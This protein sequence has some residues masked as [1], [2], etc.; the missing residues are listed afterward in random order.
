V[1]SIGGAAERGSENNTKKPETQER[2]C[3]VKCPLLA[4]PPELEAA[5]R[6]E[7][8]SIRAGQAPTSTSSSSRETPPTVVL[9]PGGESIDSEVI[10]IR[11]VTP[12]SPL[13]V[14]GPNADAGIAV[15]A[16]RAGA[17]G[18]VY[19]GMGS[20]RIARVISIAS[21][22]EVVIPRELLGE[23][24]GLRLFLKMPKILEEL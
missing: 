2:V 9:C 7:G 18:F 20:E 23:L 11:Q 24:V 13:V 6:L 8:A 22:G 12:D 16:L 5:L 15:E 1:T 3:W 19:P 17:N 21:E 10:R 14:F 4:V